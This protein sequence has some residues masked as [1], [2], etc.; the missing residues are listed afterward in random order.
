MDVPYEMLFTVVYVV[1]DDWYQR[2]GWAL[3]RGRPGVKPRFS[4]S[5]VLTLELVRELEGQ[6]KERRW[7]RT[8]RANWRG[9]VPR[10]PPRSVLHKRTQALWR[11][12]GRGAAGPGG[13]RVNPPPAA[14]PGRRSGPRRA[15]LPALPAQPHRDPDRLAQE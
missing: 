12:P 2:E 13:G 9:L 7:Y 3:V 5:E 11:A 1:V 6:T 14:R 8:V 15:G 10:L 4:D